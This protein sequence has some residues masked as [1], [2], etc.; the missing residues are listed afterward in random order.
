MIQGMTCC[1]RRLGIS[2][3]PLATVLCA[4][5]GKTTLYW[6][7]PLEYDGYLAL[8]P[9]CLLTNTPLREFFLGGYTDI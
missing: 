8:K 1:A 6:M 4:H 7:F 3:A 9:L 2:I 5:L